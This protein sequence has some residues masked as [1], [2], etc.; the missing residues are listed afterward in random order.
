MTIVDIVNVRWRSSSTRIH[1]AAVGVR[2]LVRIRMLPFESMYNN[3]IE[4]E[5]PRD[6]VTV[7]TTSVYS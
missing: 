1:V 2:V 6:R 3:E 5:S 4:R 7:D